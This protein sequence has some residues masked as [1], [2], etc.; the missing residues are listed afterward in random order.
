MC[1]SE[2][3]PASSRTVCLHHHALSSRECI[4]KRWKRGSQDSDRA[5]PSGRGH[6]GSSLMAFERSWCQQGEG[7]VCHT[8]QAGQRQLLP[9]PLGSA[10]QR[11]PPQCRQHSQSLDLNMTTNSSGA[12][13]PHL[14]PM[15]AIILH[16]ARSQS[17]FKESKDKENNIFF[18]LFSHQSP[19]FL[20]QIWK[21]QIRHQVEKELASKFRVDTVTSNP[22]AREPPRQGKQG[23]TQ[24]PIHT[25]FFLLS[26]VLRKGFKH[27]FLSG[28][29]FKLTEFCY[30][31]LASHLCCVSLI[32]TF[33]LGF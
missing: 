9:P 31:I 18:R 21:T 10:D 33:L 19:P 1:A 26:F 24:R 23:Y 11:Q 2:Q 32:Q 25:F 3:L 14:Y 7:C 29:F 22:S 4:N 6:Q 17:L 27:I 13:M 12:G 15:M 20:V 28:S 5:L 8:Q 30:S 16:L